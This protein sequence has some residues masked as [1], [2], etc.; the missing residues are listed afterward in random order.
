MAPGSNSDS[1]LLLS[2]WTLEIDQ[3]HLLL[4]MDFPNAVSGT[5]SS[6]VLQKEYLRCAA[7]GDVKLKFAAL[8]M[9][10]LVTDPNVVDFKL[11]H[12]KAGLL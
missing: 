6:S 1:T 4:T 3:T 12:K 10:L 8:A 7:C 5:V 11:W 2:S 9:C